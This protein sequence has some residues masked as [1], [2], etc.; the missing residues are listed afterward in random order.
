MRK[1]VDGLLSLLLVRWS[2][3]SANIFFDLRR[4]GSGSIFPPPVGRRGSTPLWGAR[5]S[6]PI[7][8]VFFIAVVT[9]AVPLALSFAVTIP[10]PVTTTT[11][12][13]AAR[14]FTIPAWRRR[15]SVGSPYCRGWILRPLNADTGT[16]KIPTVFVKVRIF[17]ITCALELYESVRIRVMVPGS[18]DIAS[19][20]RTVPFKFIRKLSCT[21]RRMKSAYEEDS[22][23]F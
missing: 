13:R 23:H 2:V 21:S 1:N 11:T 8:I 7:T 12:A 10:V 15:P 14:A 4:R 3:R 9:R 16:V 6:S 17:G 18:G 5:T 22:R 20:E 19:D